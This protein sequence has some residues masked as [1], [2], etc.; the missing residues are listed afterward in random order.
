MGLHSSLKYLFHCTTISSVSSSSSSPSL[1]LN[2]LPE[3]LEDL[4]N[5]FFSGL[6]NYCTLFGQQIAVSCF[7]CST[8][9]PCF[10]G[11]HYQVFL[12]SFPCHLI[13][14]TTQSKIH[15]TSRTDLDPARP[16]GQRPS[17]KEASTVHW[18]FLV[19]VGP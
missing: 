3:F 4:L 6:P 13:Q 14:F 9:S 19:I 2:S 15:Q 10:L 18:T 8:C 16:H 1:S 12:A 5:I 11:L 7:K 17:L